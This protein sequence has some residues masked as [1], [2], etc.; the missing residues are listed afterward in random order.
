MVITLFYFIYRLA[1]DTEILIRH[2]LNDNG[3]ELLR[4]MGDL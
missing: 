1:A 2:L 3:K 4:D